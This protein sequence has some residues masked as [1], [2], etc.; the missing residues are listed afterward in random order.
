MNDTDATKLI[1]DIITKAKEGSTQPFRSIR[2]WSEFRY[3]RKHAW[4]TK[5]IIKILRRSANKLFKEY[6]QDVIAGISDVKKLIAY[7]QLLDMVDFYRNELETIQAML[8]EYDEYLG[9]GNFWY[10]FLGGRREL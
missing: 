9:E 3:Y 10:S 8:N 7:N 2:Y 5:I 6:C 1:L 4:T